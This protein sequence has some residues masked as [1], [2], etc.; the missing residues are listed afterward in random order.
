MKPLDWSTEKNPWLK[1]ERQVSFEM[2]VVS[3]LEGRLI[4]V[5]RHP[6]PA[7]FPRQRIYVVEM[8]HYVY[9]VPFVEGPETIFLKTI[10]PSRKYTRT[11][12]GEEGR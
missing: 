5:I 11:H 8:N 2:V 3:I 6:N 10:H 12:L 4:N 7:R 9:L 1:R